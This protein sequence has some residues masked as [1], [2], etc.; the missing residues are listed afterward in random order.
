MSDRRWKRRWLRWW[1]D[2]SWEMRWE[3]WRLMIRMRYMSQQFKLES[4]AA[5]AASRTLICNVRFNTPKLLGRRTI[6]GS[7]NYS[8]KDRTIKLSLTLKLPR[9][10]VAFMW[11]SCNCLLVKATLNDCSAPGMRRRKRHSRAAINSMM[12]FSPR[13]LLLDVF[14]RYFVVDFVNTESLAYP[15]SPIANLV[16]TVARIYCSLIYY[17]I[18]LRDLQ[19]SLLK[20]FYSQQC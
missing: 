11:N 3:W 6:N 19:L 12:W 7:R 10:Q 15:Q 9:K 16:F 14:T 2:M 17:L 4:A 18:I 13:A 20:L 8:S 5:A 1:T